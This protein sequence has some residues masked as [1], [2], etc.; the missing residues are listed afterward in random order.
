VTAPT[1]VP[2]MET[3]P[4]IVELR[5]RYEVASVTPF[6]QG[7]E[8]LA[9]AVGLYLA[10]SPWIVG[11]HGLTTLA[12]NDLITGLAYALLIGGFGP[13][14]ERSHARGWAACLIG[15]WTII[16]PWAIFGS[17]AVARTIASN[18]VAGSLALV[19][20]LA[21]CSLARVDA[22][23]LAMRTGTAET[24]RPGRH[25]MQ[26]PRQSATPGGR[27]EYSDYPRDYQR[28]TNPET[29]GR[30][31]DTGGTSYPR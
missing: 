1:H 21:M 31:S 5:A 12:I 7:M 2:S 8:A 20:A 11:F 15:L 27:P 16:A 18:I 22:R 4:D 14:F 19:L 3:H 25:G 29:G 30:G 26:S 28:G 23:R 6:G 10:V 13:A 9:I 24:P 17:P